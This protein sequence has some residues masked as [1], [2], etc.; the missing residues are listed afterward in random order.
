[1]E[2]S[3]IE[4][5]VEGQVGR[6]GW[7]AG[8]ETLHGVSVRDERS[9]A[10]DLARAATGLGHHGE[11]L[12]QVEIW[13]LGAGFGKDLEVRRAYLGRSGVVFRNR[14]CLVELRKAPRQKGRV[15]DLMG[16]GGL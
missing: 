6:F 4:S 16:T 8:F 14:E 12:Q 9:R 11:V 13:S 7:V 3:A 15:P 5:F 10:L 2:G 1:M